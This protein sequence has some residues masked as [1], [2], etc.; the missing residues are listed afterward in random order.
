MRRLLRLSVLSLALLPACLPAPFL[1]RGPSE[2]H[3]D[4]ARASD[5]FLVKGRA[6]YLIVPRS[7]R[8]SSLRLGSGAVVRAEA[9]DKVFAVTLRNDSGI[10]HWVSSFD[11]K[12]SP[13][14]VFVCRYGAPEPFKAPVKVLPGEEMTLVFRDDR[15]RRDV[16]MIVRSLV[17]RAELNMRFENGPPLS[18]GFVIIPFSVYDYRHLPRSCLD[19]ARK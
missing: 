6:P 7:S 13:V 8:R 11:L 1:R 12:P 4:G 14:P 3:I 15:E 16:R 9:R 17:D 2:A 5:H 10:E 18:A 19:A